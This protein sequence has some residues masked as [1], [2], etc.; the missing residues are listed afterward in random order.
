[1][2]RV[3]IADDNVQNAELLEAY[4]DGTG[5]DTRLAANG[6]ETLQV[7]RDWKP[8]VILLD[9]MMPKLSGFEV[10]KKLRADAATR[11]VGILMVTA[12]DQAND[13][14]R[15]IDAGTDDFMTKPIHKSELLLRTRA[16]VESRGEAT[17][18][19]RGLDYFRRAIQQGA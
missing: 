6:E 19:D 1:M 9:V 3:L 11:N 17:D 4:L 18:L 15:A 10:C 7:A 16:L 2:P 8:D 12:L 14:E 5:W 13:I